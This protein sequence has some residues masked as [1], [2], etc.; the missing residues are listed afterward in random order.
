MS[1]GFPFFFFFLHFFHHSLTF[2]V[3]LSFLCIA[4]LLVFLLMCWPFLHP[5]HAWAPVANSDPNSPNFC[6]ANFCLTD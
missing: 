6:F 5:P 2:P 4:I 1:S 3:L